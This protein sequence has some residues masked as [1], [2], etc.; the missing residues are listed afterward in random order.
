L[1]QADLEKARHGI[2]QAEAR[3]RYYRIEVDRA[4]ALRQSGGVNQSELDRLDTERLNAE[5][6]VLV[7]KAATE[8]AKINLDFTK[9]YAPMAGR[10]SNLLAPGNVVRPNRT[11][12]GTLITDDPIAIVV[13]IPET[14][15]LAMFKAGGA[16]PAATVGFAD[17]E[18]YPHPAR[19]ESV[20]AR[21]DPAS[22]T[23]QLRFA[24]PATA[25]R[26]LPGMT[27]RV[28]LVTN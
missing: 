21:S 12:L 3:V 27:A 20:S 13:T 14:A 18:G 6:T 23:V 1:Y 10:V 28:R 19:L 7:A 22:G 5:A 9:I 8:Q 4:K 16:G 2:T 25:R 17:E 11:V 26:V 24:M 15:A